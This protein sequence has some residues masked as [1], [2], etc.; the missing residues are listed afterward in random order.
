MFCKNC[1]KKISDDAKFCSYCGAEQNF[2]DCSSEDAYQ[3]SQK[4]VSKNEI[5]SEHSISSSTSAEATQIAKK[6]P[7]KLIVWISIV[8]ILAIVVAMI[9]IFTTKKENDRQNAF[10]IGVSQSD[11]TYIFDDSDGKNII[12][13]IVPK[14][15]F[16]NFT[17]SITYYA[18]KGLLNYYKE[19]YSVGNVSAGTELVYTKLISDIEN[20]IR[21]AFYY[22]SASTVSGK[23]QYKNYTKPKEI[24]PNTECDFSFSLHHPTEQSIYINLS[25]TN[26]TNYYI[27]EIRALSVS[28]SFGGSK[29]TKFYTQRI[30]LSSK[31]APGESITM[32]NLTGNFT[33]QGITVSSEAYVSTNYSNQTYQVIYS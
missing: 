20:E 13:T 2:V 26:N 11:Y 17:F 18:E 31:L 12:S 1:G 25:I 23:K 9:V 19:E 15:D 28:I 8:L 5:I 10:I 32:N 22:A 30:K 21:G 3:S 33:S 6:K 14:Y 24:T 4:Y 7:K 29:N 16:E 27:S